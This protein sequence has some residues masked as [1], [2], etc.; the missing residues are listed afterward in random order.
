[1]TDEEARVFVLDFAIRRLSSEVDLIDKLSVR[2]EGERLVRQDF[3]QM[4]RVAK[5]MKEEILNA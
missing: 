4:K 3:C 5:K 2:G 1:M